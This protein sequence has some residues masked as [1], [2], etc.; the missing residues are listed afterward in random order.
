MVNSYSLQAQ[1]RELPDMNN[2]ARLGLKV[3]W[4]NQADMNPKREEVEYVVV[5]ELGVFVQSNGGMLTAFN[6]ETGVKLWSR[7]MTRYDE[8]MFP[9][10]ANQENVIVAV[11]LRLVNL[12]R[13]S[14]ELVWEINLPEV[15]STAPVLDDKQ[16][17]VGMLDGGIT[18]VNLERIKELT[19]GGRVITEPRLVQSWRYKT[20]KTINSPAL[21]IDNT[22]IFASLDHSVYSVT[23]VDRKL[24]YQFE[25]D[26]AITAPI[27]SNGKRLFVASE[28]FN[29]YCLN[30]TKGQ[31]LWTFVSGLPI[32]S[33]P[34][35]L[36]DQLYLLPSRGGLIS[37]NSSDG[38]PK[39]KTPVKGIEYFIALTREFLCGMTSDGRIMMINRNDGSIIGSIPPSDFKFPV[40][41]DRTD[42]LFLCTNTGLITNIKLV[43]QEFPIYHRYPERRPVI[44]IFEANGATGET[45]SQEISTEEKP[46]TENN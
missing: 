10:T 39:W 26:A 12:D 46:A 4:W 15:P 3:G 35:A 5:D 41:N 28:D 43:D 19:R 45:S 25:T 16:A 23:A 2:L 7:L 36:Y 24:N 33:K 44:P 17:Y 32:R 38:S 27:E 29:F 34:I 11:G 31:V 20:G 18:A 30:A 40:L 8:T 22:V 1:D 42:R 37:I 9:V 14:G 21:I 6:A 13:F